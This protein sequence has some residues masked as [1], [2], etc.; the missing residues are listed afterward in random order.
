MQL[1]PLLGPPCI[2]AF[3]GYL[4]NR[5]A[6]RM[7]FRPLRPW[8]IFGLRVPLTPGI[9]PAKRHALA[10][11][12]GE[13]VGKKLLT[14]EELGRA[15]AA[16][17]FQE[18]L[19]GLVARQVDEFCE[20]EWPP[21]AELAPGEDGAL[22][23][24]LTEALAETVNA[25][26]AA[27]EAERQLA[28]WLAYV[29]ANAD[30]AL[31]RPLLRHLLSSAF[32]ETGRLK[33]AFYDVKDGD[34]EVAV[35]YYMLGESLVRHRAEDLIAA[36]ANFAP[37]VGGAKIEIEAEGRAVVP[38]AHAYYLAR[39]RFA[40]FRTPGRV[41]KSWTEVVND[42]AQPFRFACVVH[43]GLRAYDWTDLVK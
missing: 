33:H 25:W 26:L 8:H 11:S 34:E 37:L 19:S 15:I 35:L 24:G 21:L 16:A 1:L 12:I 31:F 30:A 3:I 29:G 40:A 32:G 6:I 36:A 42:A 27:P 18:R 43:G 14:S 9:I 17:P 5:I 13:M 23:E 2:G 39:G 41:P 28:L 38:A 4:T 20:R 22:R 10:R 7:L